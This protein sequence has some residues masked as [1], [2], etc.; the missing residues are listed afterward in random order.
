MKMRDVL[1]RLSHRQSLSEEESYETMK[2]LLNGA[3]TDVEIAAFLMGLRTKGEHIDELY[4]ILRAL[5]E[6]AV[7]IPYEEDNLFDNCGTGGDG[8]RTF[9]I[10][11][12][13]AFVCSAAGMKVAKHGNRSITSRSGSADVLQ[14][15]G[16]NIMGSPLALSQQLKRT[17]I[18]FL[19]AQHVHPKL[20]QIGSIRKQLGIVTAFNMLGPLANP[21]P[22]THQLMGVFQEE[23]MEPAAQ[24]MQRLGRQKAIIL[25]GTPFADEATLAGP[26]KMAIVT[27]DVIHYEV[28]SPKEYGFSSCGIEQIE[29]GDVLKNKE[30][31]LSV[32]KGEKSPYY[33]TVLL[34]SALCFYA[35]E[36]V[37]TM[38]AGIELAAEMI[39]S[40]AALYNLHQYITESNR[41][42]RMK[43][44]I[45]GRHFIGKA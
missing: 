25:H 24:L 44:D 31:T 19:F 3:F 26:V 7:T 1:T 30:I 23:M 42:E 38:E 28:F 33:E 16:A 41:E 21:M 39:G 18:T 14:A 17:N 37:P 12:T 15:L 5:G 8:L 6:H 36:V 40:G 10:S 45:F 22:L 13:T 34:N 2:V 9:N 20:A 32:L 11:T 29:G 43:D 35:G 27:P 4:G